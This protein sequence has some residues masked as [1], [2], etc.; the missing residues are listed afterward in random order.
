MAFILS[1]FM[2]EVDARR[3]VAAFYVVV[4]SGVF[5]FLAVMLLLS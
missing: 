3:L 4:T 5:V 2:T 1:Q